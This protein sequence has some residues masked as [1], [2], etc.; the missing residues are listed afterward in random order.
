MSLNVGDR[1]PELELI[2]KTDDGLKSVPIG[3]GCGNTQV[4]FFYPLA[5]SGVCTKEMCDITES[6]SSFTAGDALVYGIS[7]DNPFA[8]ELWTNA[9]GIRV[10]MLSD[11]NHEAV[12]EFG[13]EDDS[14]KLE[15][16]VQVGVAQRSVFVIDNEGTIAHVEVSENPGVIPD[17]DA[18]RKVVADLA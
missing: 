1:A 5:G 9:H 6:W 2:Q 18:V 12:K 17:L 8:Q 15:G 7:G 10:P 16:V 14:F 13:V 11:Y 3:A 4:L